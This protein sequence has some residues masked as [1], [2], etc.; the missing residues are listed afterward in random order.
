MKFK[1]LVLLASLCLIL[2]CSKDD[3]TI[4]LSSENKILSF[5]IENNGDV[6]NG[7]INQDS[8]AITVV[9]NDLDISNLISPEITISNKAI[10]TPSAS[11]SFNFSI[12]VAFTVKAENGDEAIYTVTTIRSDSK[13]LSFNISPNGTE[14]IGV[15][16]HTNNTVSIETM[17]IEIDNTLIPNISISQGATINPSLNVAQDFSLPISYTVTAENGEQR[18]YSVIINNTPL[19]N[20]K[21]ILSF[22]V[23]LD[24]ETFIGVIDDTNLTIALESYILDFSGAVPTLT[25]SENATVNPDTNVPQNFNIGVPYT[26]TAANGSS[27]IY[28][29]ITKKFLFL[30]LNTSPI[31]SNSASLYYQNANPFVRTQNIDLTIPNAKIFI[32]NS[33]NS[34][35]LSYTNYTSNGSNSNISTRFKIDFP[36]NITSATDYKIVYK[37]NNVI[38]AITPYTIDILAENVPIISSTNQTSYNYGDTMVLSGNN[39][40]PGLRVSA[41]NISIYQYNQNFMS[42]NSASDTLTFPLT[43][44]HLMFPGFAG[45][46]SPHP[47]PV[48]IFHQGRHGATVILDFN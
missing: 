30:T 48:T 44:N 40:V 39:L 43:V 42:V 37:V 28:T 6:F 33:A 4:V 26:V 2:N 25:I 24:G 23:T 46:P 18:T 20:E 16:D 36:I 15:I 27:N 34:Y 38:K 9:V 29:V 7:I 31:T 35:E 14:Y 17:G 41:H 3:E 12:P 22:E 19:S 8:K 45:Q 32:E 1:F 10:I 11:V 13:I 47:T 5:K 21:R